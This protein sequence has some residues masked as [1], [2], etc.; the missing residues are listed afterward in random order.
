VPVRFKKGGRIVYIVMI[1]IRISGTW[2][3]CSWI[4][5]VCIYSHRTAMKHLGIM[6]FAPQFLRGLILCIWLVSLAIHFSVFFNYLTFASPY[7][8]FDLI[9]I[10]YQTS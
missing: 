3:P 6:R 7:Q 1:R 5:W 2:S 9:C 10:T 8:V 4:D